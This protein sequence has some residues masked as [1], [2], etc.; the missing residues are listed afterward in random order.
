MKTRLTRPCGETVIGK[1]ED[2]LVE[3]TRQHLRETGPSLHVGG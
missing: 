1:D 2:E 3:L